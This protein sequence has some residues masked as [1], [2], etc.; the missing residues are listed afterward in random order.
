MNKATFA[1]YYVLL[2]VSMSKYKVVL[3]V[4]ERQS[5]NI[6]V[7]LHHSIAISYL[8]QHEGSIGNSSLELVIFCGG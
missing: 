1:P 5:I 6:D 3:S 8:L 2:N 7:F 4:K